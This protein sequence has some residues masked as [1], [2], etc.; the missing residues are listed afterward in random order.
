MG[1]LGGTMRAMEA[2]TEKMETPMAQ[3]KSVSGSPRGEATAKETTNASDSLLTIPSAMAREALALS[4]ASIDQVRLPLDIARHNA[5]I[6]SK[7]ILENRELILTLVKKPNF[8]EVE[9]LVRLVDAT[10]GASRNAKTTEAEATTFEADL[11][12][13]FPLRKKMLSG[14]E[15]AGAAGLLPTK[16]VDAIRQGRGKLD[17]ADDLISLASLFTKHKK[18]LDGKT[19][20]TPE[21]LQEA[22]ALGLRLKAK[23][24][25]GAVKSKKAKDAGQLNAADLRDRL[26]TMVLNAH[27]VAWKLGAMVLGKD[28]DRHVPPLGTRIGK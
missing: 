27:E 22:K 11:K 15:A 24:K 7:A 12:L 20:V 13:L 26:Y 19:A 28:V 16:E 1:T 25:P 5:A 8:A 3:K 10:I 14:A 18:K 6:G 4:D 21:N 2:P 23:L 9:R 17:A